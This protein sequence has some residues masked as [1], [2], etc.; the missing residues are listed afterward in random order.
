MRGPPGEDKT[1]RG[2][3]GPTSGI[4]ILSF[5]EPCAGAIFSGG[6]GGGGGDGGGGEDSSIVGCK[7]GLGCNRGVS[8]IVD[9]IGCILSDLTGLL[10]C[11]AKF[12]AGITD[13][14]ESIDD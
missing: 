3:P 8:F 11:W 13:E 4:A 2:E 9:F 1:I 12:V 7:I 14:L 5:P 10:C 6:G